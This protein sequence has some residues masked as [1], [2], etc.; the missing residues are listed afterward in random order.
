VVVDN[1]ARLSR[2]LA[3]LPD[4]V[5]PIAPVERR[6]D[7][8]RPHQNL[9]GPPV[10]PG[11]H[12]MRA[13]HVSDRQI[14][15]LVCDYMNGTISLGQLAEMIGTLYQTSWIDVLVTPR[16]LYIWGQWAN[17]LRQS[18]QLAATGLRGYTPVQQA[19]VATQLC[20]MLSSSIANLRIGHDIS[21]NTLGQAVAPRLHRGIGDLMHYFL[22]FAGGVP[23]RTVTLSFETS[24]VESRWGGR[25][26]AHV[27]PPGGYVLVNG[28]YV[29]TAPG[30]PIVLS[31]QDPVA[32]NPVATTVG[33]PR[34]YPLVN[35]GRVPQ[36][37]IRFTRAT[38]H[39]LGMLVLLYGLYMVAL[40]LG[41]RAPRYIARFFGDNGEL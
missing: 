25:I 7:P 21:D 22:R 5:N 10:V 6:Y 37:C 34:S 16:L 1:S 30:G 15:Q 28:V 4:S 20:R 3:L 36:Y 27:T 23:L 14:Q 38:A 13:H 2:P 19:Q 32:L 39:L 18:L 29:G 26:A 9:L 41:E 12:T 8:S 35:A 24:L 17:A 33:M 40:A 31:E 11:Q